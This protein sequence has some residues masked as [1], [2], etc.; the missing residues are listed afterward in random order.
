MEYS[1]LCRVHLFPN[2]TLHHGKALT[3]ERSTAAL[4]DVL[5]LASKKF[6]VK[7]NP[8]S[9]TSNSG[10]GSNGDIHQMQI[11][12]YSCS[13]PRLFTIKGT[14][15]GEVCEILNDDVLVFVP[16]NEDFLPPLPLEQVIL[17]ASASHVHAVPTST[18]MNAYSSGMYGAGHHQMTGYP[19]GTP[20]NDGSNNP[21]FQTP[22]RPKNK[23][24]APSNLQAIS[25][26]VSQ[27]HHHHYQQSHPS[28]YSSPLSSATSSQQQFASPP[29]SMDLYDQRHHNQY[30]MA[31]FAMG[32]AHTNYMAQQMNFIPELYLLIFSFLDHKDLLLHVALVCKQWN[33]EYAKSELLWKELC[34]NIYY[35]REKR[36]RQYTGFSYSMMSQTNNTV[37]SYNGN[38]TVDS[39]SIKDSFAL[40]DLKKMFVELVKPPMEY[41]SWKTYL[42]YYVLWA[43][44]LTWD[45]TE[46]GPN[47]KFQ[48]QNMTVLRDDN[49]T[50]HWQTVRATIP[51]HVP[52]EKQKMTQGGVMV[53]NSNG[54][55][56]DD[57]A[58]YE[59]E[60]VVNK[61]DRSHSNGW[62]IVI[63]L[64]TEHFP[65]KESTPTNLIGYDRHM[66][67]GYACGNG[68]SLHCYSNTSLK[69]KQP[70]TCDPVNAWLNVPYAQGD[71]VRVRLKFFA[72]CC[73][74][75][76][77]PKEN[78]G[79]TLDYFV[80]GKWMGQAFRNITGT[81]YP[82][83]SLLTNQAVTLRH[84]DPILNKM[85]ERQQMLLEQRQLQQE[86]IER[87]LAEQKNAEHQEQQSAGAENRGSSGP[88]SSSSY[89]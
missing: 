24:S 52:T 42:R 10:A 31:Q 44:A 80:N 56:T 49:I 3:F 16:P 84:V 86:Q 61:F 78:I 25:P 62:W 35:Y 67:W 2:G 43:G 12:P 37:G 23:T 22:T 51:I 57:V 65:Y 58:L 85:I 29:F 88:A 30:N 54:A 63:G 77:D 75:A 26:L 27:Q 59:W 46:R 7:Y 66:G 74:D 21:Q 4:G 33:N 60:I 20:S 40:E 81:V 1:Y 50:Y 19:S 45:T 28:P 9:P 32:G 64:E 68:D 71:V 55:V 18:Y 53:S 69:N 82:A 87:E 8:T 17:G 47:I 89:R 5:L 36:K 41:K 76:I 11:N 13:Y 34:M 73:V 39:S 72:K 14:E 70:Y 79:A 48:N 6:N 15:I 38:L 83:V